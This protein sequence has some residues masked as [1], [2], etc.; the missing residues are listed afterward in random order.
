MLTEMCQ[1]EIDKYYMI[2]L[3]CES[4]KS[5][6]HRKGQQYG[7][8]QGLA[9]GRGEGGGG[10]RNREM[11]AKGYKKIKYIGQFIYIELLSFKKGTLGT[12]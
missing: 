8:C 7:G 12:P 11:L 10:G 4:K 2:S 9:A 5:Q 1:T 6:T 3:T